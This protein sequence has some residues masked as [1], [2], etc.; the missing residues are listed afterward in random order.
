VKVVSEINEN[1]KKENKDRFDKTL[2]HIPAKLFYFN[3]YSIR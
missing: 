1:F 2:A 3:L